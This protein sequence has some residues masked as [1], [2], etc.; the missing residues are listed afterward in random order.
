MYV[1]RNSLKVS[2]FPDISEFMPRRSLSFVIYVGKDLCR[3]IISVDMS[4]F[5][6]SRSLS[7]V[8]YVA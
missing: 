3:K 7:F 8:I 1:S 2:A 5:I 4:K 6:Q